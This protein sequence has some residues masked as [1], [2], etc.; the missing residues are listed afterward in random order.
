[1]SGIYRKLI[2]P[3]RSRLESYLKTIPNEPRF[4]KD[5]TAQ[6]KIRKLTDYVQELQTHI[7]KIRSTH[8]YLE[9]QH[10]KWIAFIQN[11]PTDSATKEEAIHDKYS[12]DTNFI[13]IMSDASDKLEELKGKKR[14]KDVEIKSLKDEM[15]DG[16]AEESAD[17]NE[18]EE[19]DEPQLPLSSEPFS[20]HVSTLPTDTK[21][22][23]YQVSTF[24]KHR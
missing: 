9:K 17:E 21:R 18:D 11:L 5:D 8:D 2:G 15:K 3:S 16:K 20:K 10:T 7:N 1:M 13:E 19:E 12:T 24:V 14:E 22:I 4:D 23:R 6:N